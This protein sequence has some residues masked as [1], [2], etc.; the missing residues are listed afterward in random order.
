M[1]PTITTITEAEAIVATRKGKAG[2]RVRWAMEQ[3]AGLKDG[4][5]LSLWPDEDESPDVWRTAFLSAA[6]GYGRRIRTRVV[7]K[8]LYVRWREPIPPPLEP[9]SP[10]DE[11]LARAKAQLDGAIAEA[12]GA[13]V[14]ECPHWH[15]KEAGICLTCERG[16]VPSGYSIP[17]ISSCPWEEIPHP[18]YGSEGA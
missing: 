7:D 16:V 4:Q 9:K 3:L 8:T 12:R 6:A 5:A 18:H 15:I 10:A 17:D 2:E 11:T 1:M 13:E 14:V